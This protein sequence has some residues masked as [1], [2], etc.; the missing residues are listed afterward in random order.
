MKLAQSSRFISPADSWEPIDLPGTVAWCYRP[1]MTT[2]R[3]RAGDQVSANAGELV[4]RL[5]IMTQDD[6]PEVS[7]VERRCFANPWPASAYRRELQNPAQNY[8]VVLRAMQA[9]AP[10]RPRLDNGQSDAPPAEI[11]SFPRGPVPRRS[12][13]SIKRGRQQ[14]SNGGEPSPIVGFAGMWLAFDEAHVTT[15]GV[16]PSHRGLGLGELLLLCMFD[17]A[18]A[19]AAN[20]LTLEVRITNAPAQALYRKYGFTAHGTRK[21]YYSD[22]NEDALIMWSPALDEP[23]YRSKVESRRDALARRLGHRLAPGSLAPFQAPAN[24]AGSS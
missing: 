17:E 4:Y 22:N 7:R 12:L 3:A 9:E 11:E 10:G 13:L 20:W 14:E 21:R 16:D 18:V 1:E 5:D 6:V 19:R 2:L 24:R 8:Y 15:I 23:E